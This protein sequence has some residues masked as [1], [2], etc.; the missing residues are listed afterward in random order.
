MPSKV[1]TPNLTTYDLVKTL[2]IILTVLDHV[3][4]FFYPDNEWFRV[5]GRACIPIWCFLVGYANSRDTGKDILIWATVLWLSNFIFGGNIFPLN[6][7]FTIIACRLL[8]DVT[9][10][11]MF[12]NWEPMLYG[13][14]LFMLAVLPT[15]FMVEYGTAALLLVLAGYAV[16]HRSELDVSPNTQRL[17]ILGSVTIYALS[18]LV[19][20]PFDNIQQKACGFMI[21]ATALMMYFFKPLEFPKVTNLTPR[22]ITEAIQFTGRYTME[23]YVV[24]LILFKAV[25]A[26]YGLEKYGFFAWDWVR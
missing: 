4:Y 6:M 19:L 9:A 20:F 14:A 18:Q 3:G 26:Y 16:R 2:A 15:M 12:K 13:F 21:G 24:H 17:Y 22:F 25:A 10:R 23:I 5:V 1:I 8:L 11:V 7:L